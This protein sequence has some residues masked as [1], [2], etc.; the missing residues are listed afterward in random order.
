MDLATNSYEEECQRQ[1]LR[2]VFAVFESGHDPLQETIAQGG[3]KSD[4][5]EAPWESGKRCD[6]L[7]SHPLSSVRAKRKAGLH[8]ASSSI[9]FLLFNNHG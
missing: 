6:E 5:R 3:F 1:K 9:D 2:V 8:P 7:F 4:F